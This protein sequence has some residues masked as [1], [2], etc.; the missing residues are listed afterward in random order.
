MY[1][2]CQYTCQGDLI[3]GAR[4]Q[5]IVI[6]SA[7]PNLTEHFTSS[8]LYSFTIEVFK[9]SQVIFTQTLYNK[10]PQFD[11]LLTKTFEE[12]NIQN[13]KASYFFRISDISEYDPD[14]NI[15]P[16]FLRLHVDVYNQVHDK[17]YHM[18]IPVTFNNRARQIEMRQFTFN[19]YDRIAKIV[20]KFNRDQ[21]P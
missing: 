3:C 13:N 7:L 6:K 12:Q 17:D 10:T 1:S 4:K 18:R 20:V 5:D 14:P 21:L 15:P 2:T 9:N 16:K 8:Q 19:M 11:N